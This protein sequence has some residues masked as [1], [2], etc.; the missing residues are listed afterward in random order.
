MRPG[1]VAPPLPPPLTTV[2]SWSDGAAAGGATIRAPFAPMT[3]EP[4]L[5]TPRPA[6]ELTSEARV[7][8]AAPEGEADCSGGEE[9]VGEAVIDPRPLL[10]VPEPGG[11]GGTIIAKAAAGIGGGTGGARTA[12]E[13]GIGTPAGR[14]IEALPPFAVTGGGTGGIIIIIIIGGPPAV[15]EARPALLGGGGGGP[16][17][18]EGGAGAVGM[19]VGKAGGLGGESTPGGPAKKEK[20]GKQNGEK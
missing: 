2:T 11:N 7:G 3:I 13:A 14:T 8:D 17:G 6:L 4:R 9:D 12:I 20:R 18:S 15:I 19:L 5:L 1:P 10:A 16:G